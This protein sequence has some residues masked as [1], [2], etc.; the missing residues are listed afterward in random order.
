[1]VE[2]SADCCCDDGGLI[3]AGTASAGTT[4]AGAGAHQQLSVLL[5]QVV[6]LGIPG[7]VVGVTGHGIRRYVK[8][9]GIAAPNTPMTPETRFRIGSITKTFTATVILQLVD[10]GALRLDQSI[11]KWEPKIPNAR[12]ITIRMLLDMTS[13]IWDEGARSATSRSGAAP[14]E[15]ARCCG[16][17]RSGCD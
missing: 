12:H 15:P 17:G 6:G 11:A 5:G 8:A 3:G 13:G 1:V 4:G 9:F 16:P 10:R 2:T 14:W 7:G